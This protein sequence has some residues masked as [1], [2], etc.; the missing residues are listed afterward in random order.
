MSEGTPMKDVLDVVIAGAARNPASHVLDVIAGL[1]RNPCGGRSG[2][3][4]I[5]GQARDDIRGTA[6]GARDDIRG[7]HRP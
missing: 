7:S 3:A 6:E 1:T 5:P 2:A 4:W